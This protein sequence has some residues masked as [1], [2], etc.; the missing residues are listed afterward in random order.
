MAS[1]KTML[2]A[3]IDFG[4]TYS[5]YAFSLRHTYEKDPLKIHANQAWNAGGRQLLSLKTP[6][7]LLLDNNKKFVSFGYE[8][9]NEYANLAMD[10]DQDKYYYFYRFKMKLHNNKHITSDMAVEDITGRTLPAIDVFSLSIRALKDHL[11]E[12]LEKQGTGLKVDEIKWVLTVPA[13]WSDSA[14]QFMRAS[15]EK[16]EIP[17][18]RLL[19]ALEP[20]AASI[21]CQ[22]L[23]IEK[24]QGARTGF[25]MTKKGTKFMIID[26]GGGTADITVHEKLDGTRLKELCKASGDACGGT[27]VDNAFSQT[28]VKILGGPVMRI[29]QKEY[30]SSYMDLFREFE[31]LKRTIKNSTS[32]KVN[33]TVPY[34]VLDQICKENLD[35]DFPKTVKA[36][37]LADKLSILGDKIRF[38]AEFMKS[39][40]KPTID[41]IITHVKDVLRKKESGDVDIFL[42]V[43]GF[44]ESPM[45]QE[46]IRKA[47]PNTR[48]I[49]PEDSGISV[50]KGAVLFGHRPD[51]ISSRIARYTYGVKIAEEFDPAK[52]DERKM[53]RMGNVAHCNDIFSSFM[54]ADT[55]VLAGQ[56]IIK[57]Y[58]TSTPFQTQMGL[59]VYCT[60]LEDPKYVDDDG[61]TLLGELDVTVPNPSPSEHQLAVEFHFGNTE[62]SVTAVEI[63]SLTPCKAKFKL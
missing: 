59:R 20:E 39:L 19:I 13:I 7:C 40:Y 12:E 31:T 28:F 24:L 26:L 8:A 55:S 37:T 30:T 50:L 32:G 21:Y 42:L 2:V 10:G 47:F 15:A 4:T 5:G 1:D 38:D 23:P 18:E 51:F 16:A 44:S 52:H 29:L 14:K 9:E 63:P 60:S 56:K 62:L 61:C 48:V 17:G 27:S 36:S 41:N 25:S 58:A 33:F 22:H 46:A 53:I 35:E 45:I 54:K 3:A 11:L 34:V 57:G 43:G 49:V 6:T